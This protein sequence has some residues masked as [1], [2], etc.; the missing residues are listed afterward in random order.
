MPILVW[1]GG[2]TIHG[3]AM[4]TSRPSQADVRDPA[5][6]MR[7]AGA[8]RAELSAV[9]ASTTPPPARHGARL[10]SAGIG[11]VTRPIP[12]VLKGR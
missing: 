10:G 3:S 11:R 5:S 1:E 12:S 2:L 6:M 7:A 9:H 8:L 4:S